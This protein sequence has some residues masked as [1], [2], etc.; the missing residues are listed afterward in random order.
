M[1]M[2]RP[3]LRSTV[4]FLNSLRRNSSGV[5]LIEFAY[6]LPMVL[7]VVMSG[8]ELTNFATTQM[9]VNQAALQLADNAARIGSETPLVTKTVNEGDIDDV[10]V[11]AGLQFDKLG[12]LYR[13][14]RVILS[15]V[16]EDTTPSRTNKYKIGWQRCRGTKAVASSYGIQGD[17]NKDGVGPTG[18]QVVAPSGGAVMFVEVKYDYQPFFLDGFMDAKTISATA[19]MTVRNNRNLATVAPTAGVTIGTCS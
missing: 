7:L 19:A 2:A 17:N 11:G 1:T 3:S 4:R 13:N 16:E 5:V 18:R 12:S 14:G 10:L 9:N 15:S 8:S 6:T